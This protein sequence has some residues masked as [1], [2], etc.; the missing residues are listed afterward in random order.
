[1]TLPPEVRVVAAANPPDQAAD[2]W[3]LAPPLANRLVH[4]D[5]PTDGRYIA[6]GLAVGFPLPSLFAL[7]GGRPVEAQRLTARATVAAFLEVRPDLALQLPRSAADS[8]RGWPSPRSWE[9]VATLLAACTAA[10]ASE[11]ARDAA[12][13]GRRRRRRRRS[14]S[15][16][17]SSTSTCP[18]PRRCS[19]TPTASSCPSG[20][21]ARSR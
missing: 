10:R 21:T 8:G 12:R 20:A 5:W 19:P 9:A 18:T 13:H 16:P 15:S 11:E 4:I 3:E 6:H 17:G 2:G 14:S 7:D 1:M